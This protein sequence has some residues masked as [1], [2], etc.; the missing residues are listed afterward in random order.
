MVSIVST[1]PHHSVVKEAICKNC[2]CT[3]SYV[4]ADVTEQYTTD[5]TGG[6]DYYKAITC[7]ACKQMVR[8]S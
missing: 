2:G 7:P 5:Y 4:P 6:R 3:L 1:N 8:V